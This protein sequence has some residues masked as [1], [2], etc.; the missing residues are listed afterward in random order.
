[1]GSWQMVFVHRVV[2]VGAEGGRVRMLDRLF[3]PLA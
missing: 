3:R 2:L 1:M